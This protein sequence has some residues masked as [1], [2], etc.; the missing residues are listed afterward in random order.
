LWVEAVIGV[1][2][3]VAKRKMSSQS[4]GGSLGIWRATWV[5]GSVPSMGIDIMVSRAWDVGLYIER[6]I[7]RGRIELTMNEIEL[8]R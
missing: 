7:I 5:I 4:S 3:E 6:K 1:G 2:A 8:S